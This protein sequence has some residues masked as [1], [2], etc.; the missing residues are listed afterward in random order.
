MV[1][2]VVVLLLALFLAV[3]IA[4]AMGLAGVVGMGDVP[5][6]VA[7]QQI[8]RGLDSFTLVAIPLFLLMGTIMARSGITSDLIGLANVVVGRFRGGLAHTNI[9]SSMFF[10]GISGS[11]VADLSSIGAVMIPAMKN[12]GYGA[13]FSG[14]VTAASCIIGP[15]IPPSILMVI[16]AVQS[17][18]SVGDLFLAGAVPG[19]ILGLGMLIVSWNI[20]RLRDYP[21]YRGTSTRESL[22]TTAKAVPGLGLPLLIVFGVVAGVFT[23]TESAAIAVVYALVLAYAKRSINLRDLPDI[24]TSAT[25]DSAAVSVVIAFS[26]LLAY[27]VVRSGAPQ[28][29]VAWMQGSFESAWAV[30][31]LINLFLLLLGMFIAPAA[32]LI[33]A[34]PL[35]LPVAQVYAIDPVQLGVLIVFN[36]NLGLLTPP[37]G[38]ALFITA[39]IAKTTVEGQFREV[40]PFFLIAV[41]TL[42]LVTF[43]PGTSLALVNWLGS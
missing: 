17:G 31:I 27:V 42:G 35:L 9:S 12:Q 6:S 41:A 15:I 5:L 29:L 11:A 43:V 22:V 40:L 3:P 14:A 32:G 33:I 2:I 13:G 30:L 21:R 28:D 37:V 10:A 1:L 16:F 38:I 7:A 26:S 25:K 36:L 20:A 4:Y 23:V 8:V 19:V 18:Q 34:T 39:R 24:V